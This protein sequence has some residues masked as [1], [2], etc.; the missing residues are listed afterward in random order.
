MEFLNAF[1]PIL[2][3]VVAIILIV[4]LIVIGLRIINILDK[5]DVLVDDVQEKVDTLNSAVALVKTTADGIS[6][7][8]NS[9]FYKFSSVASK[10]VNIFSKKEEK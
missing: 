4:V 1:L 5:L 10:V 8:S 6:N 7:I 2:L 9:V 3:Y